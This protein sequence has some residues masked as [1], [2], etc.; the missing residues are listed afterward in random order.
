MNSEREKTVS[1]SSEPSDSLSDIF[2]LTRRTCDALTHVATCTSTNDLAR[3][4]YPDEASFARRMTVGHGEHLQAGHMGSIQAGQEDVSREVRV[5]GSFPPSCPLGLVVADEQTQ[6][7]GRRGRSWLSGVEDSLIA[8]YA[9]LVP[10]SLV[11]GSRIGVLTLAAGLAVL[12]ALREVVG[13]RQLTDLLGLKWPNDIF[14]SGRKLAGILCEIAFTNDE[15]SGVIV[16]VGANLLV[17]ADRL[18]TSRATSLQL[19]VKSLPAFHELRDRLCARIARGFMQQIGTLISGEAEAIEALITRIN[20]ENI[21]RG[22]AVVVERSCGDT[23]VGIAKN[24]RR[25]GSLEVIPTDIEAIPTD[26]DRA[27]SDE[28][29]AYDTGRSSTYA[30]P[31]LVTAGDVSLRGVGW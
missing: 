10:S 5:N 8:S 11:R 9:L 31:I 13:D 7:R 22:E 12:D 4:L 1:P 16:G 24:V 18:P 6:G 21:V 20:E 30:E 14:L 25:D 2:P 27:W 17:P 29:I 28:Q 3:R 15:S 19:H 26:T 23:L